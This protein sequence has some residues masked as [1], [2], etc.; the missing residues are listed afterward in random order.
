MTF[1]WEKALTTIWRSVRFLSTC[2]NPHNV[3]KLKEYTIVTVS[4]DSV[5]KLIIQDVEVTGGVFAYHSSKIRQAQE[6]TG[7]WV[8]PNLKLI[9]LPRSRLK[10]R[11]VSGRSLFI[12]TSWMHAS[13]ELP[14]LGYREISSSPRRLGKNL[15]S[16]TIIFLSAGLIPSDLLGWRIVP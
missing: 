12:S 4:I 16:S 13:R 1:M 9:L 11:R 8:H 15:C 7:D 5:Y 10:R 6:N 2:T 14:I 3:V